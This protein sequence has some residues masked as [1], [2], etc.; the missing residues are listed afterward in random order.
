MQQVTIKMA[1][2]VLHVARGISYKLNRFKP[3]FEMVKHCVFK[4]HK[5]TQWEFESTGLVL[6]WYHVRHCW[7]KFVCSFLLG[8][9]LTAK[10]G[11]YIHLWL[12]AWNSLRVDGRLVSICSLMTRSRTLT[13][14]NIIGQ[15]I[16][17]MK[18]QYVYSWWRD[19]G[20]ST[21]DGWCCSLILPTKTKS[22]SY[23]IP[24]PNLYIFAFHCGMMLMNC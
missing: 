11:K 23:S 18:P 2:F 5:L 4:Q 10:Y 12:K 1:H 6:R 13:S 7:F 21:F 17:H 20:H 22:S 9:H 8:G 16:T 24:I 15:L 19:G 3:T 14:F